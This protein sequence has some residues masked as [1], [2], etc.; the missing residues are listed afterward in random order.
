[1]G[2]NNRKMKLPIKNA[3]QAFGK[4]PG[5][6]TKVTNP[7]VLLKRNNVLFDK[8]NVSLS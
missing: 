4:V 3:R 7:A 8:L 6:F 1:M 2:Q 5:I